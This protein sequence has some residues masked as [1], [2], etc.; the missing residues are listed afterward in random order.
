M[1]AAVAIPFDELRP[2]SAQARIRESRPSD[3]PY[4][5]DSWR[6]S[7]RHGGKNRRLPGEAYRGMFDELVV[8]GVLALPETRVL[9]SC[10]DVDDDV[11]LGWLCYAPGRI[12][13]V[14]YGLVLGDHEHSMRRR[15]VFTVLLAAA[16]V[17]DALVYTFRAPDRRHRWDRHRFDLE[18]ALV[19]AGLA[20]GITAHYVPVRDYLRGT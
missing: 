17:D 19:A 15:G 20:R 3:L 10:D 7:W 16:G 1:I 9:V 2:P 4:V 11:V 8:R 18:A 6:A 13:T 5:V 12:P 14:H